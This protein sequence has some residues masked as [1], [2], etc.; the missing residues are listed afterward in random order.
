MESILYK[1]L[2]P[3]HIKCF[4][5]PYEENKNIVLREGYKQHLF[6]IFKEAITNIAKHSN[7]TEVIVKV[8]SEKEKLKLTIQDNGKNVVDLK[9]DKLNGHGIKNMK[10]RAKKIKGE[11]KISI[12]NGFKLE[13]WF[14]F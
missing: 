4:F 1:L 2:T 3:L 12:D 9:R 10:L 5:I 11:L 14:D 6:L 13:L 8:T 7:A